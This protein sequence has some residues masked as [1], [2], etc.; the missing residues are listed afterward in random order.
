M[1]LYLLR[2]GVAEKDRPGLR[3]A[4]RALTEE[5]RRKL[6]EVLKTASETR[7][8]PSLILTSPLKRAAQT[9]EVAKQVLGYK[10][11]ILRTKALLPGGSV[12]QVWDEVRAHRDEPSLM[13]VGHNPLFAELSGYLLG[14]ADMQVEFKKGALLRVDFEEFRARPKGTLRWYLTAKMAAK[15]C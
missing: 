14:S 5:G 15:R 3:D 8:N 7:V 1:E 11:E 12:E 2:H 13:L 10:N 4:E 9:A 6:R